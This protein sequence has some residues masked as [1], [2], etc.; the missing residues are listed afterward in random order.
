MAVAVVQTKTGT[1]T[2]DDVCVIT[3]D[4]ST[5]SGN[6]IVVA[7]AS[8]GLK[9]TDVCLVTDNKGNTYSVGHAHQENS[10][11]NSS[12][13]WQQYTA[14]I[15]G[16]ASHAVT[17]TLTHAVGENAMSIRAT[18]YEISG[19][20]TSN[21][22]D[23]TITNEGT[24]TTPNAGYV[25][26]SHDDQILIGECILDTT[27]TYTTPSGW[28]ELLDSGDSSHNYIIDA[29][30]TSRQ[31]N[32]VGSASSTWASGAC[33]YKSATTPS[34]IYI[35][36]TF[37]FDENGTWG[38]TV[39]EALT[40]PSVTNSA[41]LVI[42]WGFDGTAGDTDCTGVTWNTTE[43]FTEAL[44]PGS[45]LD[46]GVARLRC[47]AFYLLNPTAATANLV[48][49]MG[50]ANYRGHGVCLLL[51]GVQQSA[52][53]DATASSNSSGGESANP[54]VS[55]TTVANN[56][57]ILAAVLASHE[58]A[59]VNSIN[60]G[61]ILVGYVTDE[62]TFGLAWYKLATAGSQAMTY[63]LSAAQAYQEIAVSLKPAAAASV[64]PSKLML[65]G[66]G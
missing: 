54:S 60:V 20:A 2:N 6:L 45:F 11:S 33:S 21:V 14:N 5:T 59:T 44:D 53:P 23:R 62:P 41:L 57:I 51:G 58:A 50:G 49:T 48:I 18:I 26:A 15:T 24:S 35:Y 28:T 52:Q 36:K 27:A 31:F 34:G 10:G 16:G 8:S 40:I 3:F 64:R 63:T 46:T 39:T 42:T 65:M 66:V 47:V 43:T 12:H 17:I 4:S 30:A 25:S 38:T 19:A 22:L 55:I 37:H 13:V 9:L 32:P 1:T 7:V 56:S 29:T 61:T